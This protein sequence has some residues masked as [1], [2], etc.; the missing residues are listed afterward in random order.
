MQGK[1]N[2]MP[3]LFRFLLWHI[4]LGTLAGWLFAA[5]LLFFDVG[6]FGSL[7]LGSPSKWVVLGMLA[8]MFSVTFGSA[9][10]ATAVLS[11][12]DFIDEAE[13]DDTSPPG[14]SDLELLPVRVRRH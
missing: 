4:F 8:V 9:S 5:G 7:V 10:V 2:K 1:D 14:S 11:G 13:N 3:R 12:R 6:G